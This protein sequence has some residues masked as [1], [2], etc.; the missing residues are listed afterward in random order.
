MST[1]SEQAGKE[2][3]AEAV[4]TALRI[5]PGTD[6][7]AAQLMRVDASLFSQIRRGRSRPSL[8]TAKQLVGVLDEWR[9]D[10]ERARKRLREVIDEVE[11]ET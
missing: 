11:Q 2:R 6:T 9:W 5:A 3:L 4:R 8:R 1:A 7:D 10:C